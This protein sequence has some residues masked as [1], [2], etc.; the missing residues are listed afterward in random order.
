MR[1]W[2]YDVAIELDNETFVIQ[3]ET[4]SN[5]GETERSMARV[6]VM[7]MLADDPKLRD[8]RLIRSNC[9]EIR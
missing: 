3:G 5:D 6:M 1:R 4:H 8:G 2:K 9:T 7:K